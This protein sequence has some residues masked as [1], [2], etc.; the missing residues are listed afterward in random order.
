IELAQPLFGGDFPRRSRA[1]EDLVAHVAD[2]LSRVGG[3]SGVVSEPPQQRVGV[4]EDPHQAAS[5]D[6]SSSSGRGSKN[7]S[8]TRPGR[9]P[10]RR[11]PGSAASGTSRAY[12]RPAFATMISSPAWARSSSLEKWVLASWTLTTVATVP[13]GP[14][15][16]TKSAD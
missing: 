13:P 2:R 14:G 12:G 4:E 8:P 11:P 3:K 6:R 15:Y 1:D 5:Q 10:G 16:P 7:S 9:R